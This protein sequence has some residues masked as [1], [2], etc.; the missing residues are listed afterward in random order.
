MACVTLWT[1][2]LVSCFVSLE[3]VLAAGGRQSER[4]LT[5]PW[6]TKTGGAPS[7][8]LSLPRH[9]EARLL[10]HSAPF[11][12]PL[13]LPAGFR[14]RRADSSGKCGLPDGRVLEHSPVSVT[15]G[16]L[17]GRLMMGGGVHITSCPLLPHTARAVGDS[18]VTPGNVARQRREFLSA[19][20]SGGCYGYIGMQV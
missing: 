2:M 8:I 4:I 17:Q 10:E 5:G 14:E 7:K 18:R 15:W 19:G 9:L 16:W 12:Y 11:D 20:E 3:S 1:A 6:L 13:S